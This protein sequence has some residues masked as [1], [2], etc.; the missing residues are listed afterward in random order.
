[1]RWPTLPT[2]TLVT[3]AQKA[4][5]VMADYTLGMMGKTPHEVGYSEHVGDDAL[6]GFGT[7]L[8]DHYAGDKLNERTM[9]RRLD[10]DRIYNLHSLLG[11]VLTDSQLECIATNWHKWGSPNNSI[12]RIKDVM[13]DHTAWHTLLVEPAEQE[14]DADRP[15][16]D[17]SPRGEW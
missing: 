4:C 5:L 7:L 16:R 2:E 13:V 15:P 3:S 1:M 12:D 10:A 6:G 17:A 14:G 9:Q 11:S 8:L